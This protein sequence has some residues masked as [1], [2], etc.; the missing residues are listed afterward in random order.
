MHMAPMIIDLTVPDERCMQRYIRRCSALRLT[1]SDEKRALKKKN[2]TMSEGRWLRRSTRLSSSSACVAN[3]MHSEK[4]ASKKRKTSV[5]IVDSETLEGRREERRVRRSLRINSAL[6]GTGNSACKAHAMKLAGSD[7]EYSKEETEVLIFD[8]ET[9]EERCLRRSPRISSAPEGTGNSGSKV[10]LDNLARSAEKQPPKKPEISVPIIDLTLLDDIWLR[11][12]P[13]L[14]SGL[15][16]TGYSGGCKANSKQLAASEE[17]Q[18]V[19]KRNTS[20]VI[21]DLETMEGHCLRQSPRKS[22]PPLG[23]GKSGRKFNSVQFPG[24]AEKQPA[25]KQKVS[26]TSFGLAM[27]E[28]GWRRCSPRT[29]SAPAGTENSAHKANSAKLAGRAYKWHSK[30]QKCYVSKKIK[31]NNCFFIGEPIPFE[32]A[33]KRWPWRYE[34]KGKGSKGQKAS[35]NDEDEMFLNV[36]CHYAQAEILKCVFE[37]GDFAYVKGKE[38]GPNY[39]GKILEFFKTVDGEDYFRVQWFFRAE[40]TVELKSKYIPPCDF[41]YDMKYSVDYSTFSTTVDDNPKVNSNISSSSSTDAVHMNTSGT[42][43]EVRSSH[44]YKKSKLTLLDLYSGCGGMSTGLCL[45]AKLSGVNLVTKWAVD[46]NES[47]CESLRLNHPNSQIRNESAKDFLDLLKEWEKLC[48]R[49]I[50]DLRNTYRV[51]NSDEGK[52]NPEDKISTGEYEVLR[53]VDICYG[54]PSKTGKRG[55]KFKVRW[56]GYG[57][58]DDT[59]EPI[60]E[61]SKCQDGIRDFVREGFKLKILPLPGDADVVCGGPPCQ[62]ISGYNRFRNVDAPLED[63]RNLQIVFFM[64]IVKFLKP[65]FVLMENVVDILRFADG[66]LGRY[67]LSRLVHLNY[68]ARLGI[69]AAGCY[70]LPQFRLRAFLWGA[71]PCEKLPQYPLPTHDVILRY[72]TPYEFER[73][74]VAYDEGQPRKL[75]R[76]LRLRDAISD[77]PAVTNHETREEMPHQMRPETEFQKFIRSTKYEMM[78]SLLNGE[79]TKKSVLNDH[80]PLPLNEDD[81][82]RV[83]QIP[84]RKGANFRDLPGVIVGADNVVRLDPKM[85]RVLLPSGK[86]L[87][88]DYALNLSQGKS[89]RPFARLWWDETVPTVLT[90]PEPHNKVS[91]HPEQDRVLTIREYARLQGFPDY[92]RFC[93]TLKKRYCQIGNAVAVPVARA[94]GYALGMAS[95]KLTGDEPLMTLPPKFSH[96]TALQLVQSSSPVVEE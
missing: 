71:H 92:Y 69:M 63:E 52:V 57:P 42:C 19:K 13:R 18:L 37:I 24:L 53:L 22:S 25:K 47:A 94:L 64:D 87:A 40:D 8:L 66:S 90:T 6:E 3:P 89:T 26:V 41:Y 88:P 21:I 73:N 85:E 65:K 7:E 27:S 61:L 29:S 78:G 80:R 11:R 55:L 91:L 14:S 68:Q 48:K 54:D 28:E 93:G 35:D 76:A 2:S 16:R 38:G 20:V 34:G 36:Q 49:Y 84:K 59:W 72:G 75:E 39:V 62:G 43:L 15:L 51:P 10:Q 83:C 79:I 12:S 74:T 31:G 23:T 1:V 67:A 70:G 86:P 58:S 77:L 33:C 81:Y 82:L 50:G 95:L 56:K 30:K 9:S 44:G 32:E 45:G 60:E 96:S 5:S 4:H 46:L 17:K